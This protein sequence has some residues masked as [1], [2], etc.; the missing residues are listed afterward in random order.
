MA[1][2]LELNKQ[3]IKI[4]FLVG[5]QSVCG[6]LAVIIVTLEGYFMECNHYLT[7]VINAWFAMYVD[8]YIS[9]LRKV[10][11]IWLV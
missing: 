11:R 2:S 5:D 8:V 7:V 10:I 9:L 4:A 3:G 1:V 6:R